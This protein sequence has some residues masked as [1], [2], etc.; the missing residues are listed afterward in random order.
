MKLARI[1]IGVLVAA[2]TVLF[3]INAHHS[4]QAVAETAGIEPVSDAFGSVTQPKLL[5]LLLLCVGLVGLRMM[6]RKDRIG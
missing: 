4:A 1:V 6:Q 5:D 2:L 3:F